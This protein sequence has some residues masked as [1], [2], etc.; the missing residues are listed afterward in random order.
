MDCFQR[1]GEYTW[2]VLHGCITMPSNVTS[3]PAHHWA[4]TTAVAASIAHKGEVASAEV[5]AGSIADLLARLE[6]SAKP[7]EPITC[8]LFVVPYNVVIKMNAREIKEVFNEV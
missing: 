1:F 7:K 4:A 2:A 6:L 8:L 3:I 5:P